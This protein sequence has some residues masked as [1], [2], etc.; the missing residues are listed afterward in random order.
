MEVDFELA[1]RYVGSRSGKLSLKWRGRRWTRS[2]L[3]EHVNQVEDLWNRELSIFNRTR[4]KF[5]CD[6][7][8]HR[9]SLLGHVLRSETEILVKTTSK[10]GFDK[11]G[12][13]IQP[14]WNSLLAKK[15][16]WSHKSRY[17]KF[18]RKLSEEYW[19]KKPWSLVKHELRGKF[20]LYRQKCVSFMGLWLWM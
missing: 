6:D 14:C 5:K 18:F 19:H 7:S 3:F 1:D 12:L 9:E 20:W 2:V 8:L 16:P 15:T 17:P 11:N 13:H 10:I 4:L